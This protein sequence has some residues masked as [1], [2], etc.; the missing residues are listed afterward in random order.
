MTRNM[1]DMNNILTKLFTVIM[2]MMFS[3][4]AQADVKVLFGEDGKELQPGKDGTITLP[5][6]EVMGGTIVIT[7]ED[8]KDGTTKVYLSVAPDKD[9]TMAK[10]GPEVYAVIS[11]DAA[12]TRAPEVSNRLD[13]KSDDYKDDSQK[14]TYYVTIDSNLAL[15][16]KKVEFI[17]DSKGGGQTRSFPVVTTDTNNP[18][19]YLIQSF[20]NTGFYM[21]PSVASSNTYVYTHNIL[22]DDMKWFFLDAGDGYYYICH[23]DDADIKYMYFSKTYGATSASGRVWIQLKDLDN[24]DTDH[25]KFSFAK[26]NTNS[27]DAYN[28]IPKGSTGSYCLNKRGGNSYINTGANTYDDGVQVST[29]GKGSNDFNDAG[30]NWNF[31]AFDDSYEWSLPSQC[32]TVSD[33]NNSNNRHFYKVKSQDATKGYIKPGETYVEISTINDDDLIW[34]FEEAASDDLMTYY[35]IRHANTGQYLRFCLNTTGDNATNLASR[36]GN[37]TGD[38]E[39]RFQFIVVRGT[40]QNEQVNDNSIVFNIIPK[41]LKT[42]SVKNINSLCCENTTLSIKQLRSNLE[43]KNTN[44]TTHWTFESVDY[45][46]VC[47]N[48]TITFSN[49]TGKATIAT[50]TTRSTIY[51][52]TDGTDPSSSNGMEYGDPFDVTEQ[53]TIKAIVTRTGF[54]DSEVVTKT[55]YQVATPTI[56]DNGSNAISI[57]T[58]TTE[59]DVHIYYTLDES[60]PTASSTE[61]TEPLTENV[62]GV[63]IKTIAVK[64]GWINSAVAS[65]SVTLQCAKPIFTRSGASL[66]ITCNFPSTGV[67]IYYTKDGGEPSSSSNLYEGSITVE[68]NDVI[69]AVAIASGYYD[70]PVV[71]KT[72]H[73]DLSPTDGKYL[74]NSQT[75][76]ET[77]LDMANEE[78]GASYHYV[79]KTNV[80]AGSEISQ[81]FTGVLEAEAD[82]NGNFYKISGLNHAL[83]NT[84]DGGTVKNVMFDNVNISSGTNVGAIA[85]EASGYTRIYNCGVLGGSV[86]GS[87]YVGG[88]VGWLKDDSRVINCFSYANITSGNDVA[89]IVGHNEI[90]STTEVSDGKYAN[91]KTVVV[92]CMF[93]GN[94]TGGSNRYPVYGG[95]KIVNNTATGINNYDFYRAE[96]SVGTLTDYNCSWPAKEEYLTKYEFYRNLLN[97]N[98]ELCGWWVSATSAPSTMT[99]TA[100]QAVPKDASL[101]AKWVLDQSVAPYPILKKFGKYASSIN[102]DAD[103]SWRTT[104][105][106]WEGKKLG[107]LNVTVESGAQ[108][109][110]SDRSL[111]LT[112]TDMDTLRAD[113]CYRKV[114]LPYYN[115][116][117]G[118]PNG[119]DWAAKYGGN[120]G[121]Y[122]VIGWKVSTTE[123]NAGE[124]ST[125]WETGYNFADRNCTAKDANRVFAQGGYYYVPNGVENITITAQWASAIY[126]DNTDRYYDRVSV[127]SFTTISG[128][129][130]GSANVSPFEP[131]GT[132]PT[133]LGN[134]KTVQIGSISSK[135]PSNGTVYGNAIVLVGNH[136][137]FTG[138][139][140][141][142]NSSKGGTIMSADFDFDDEP[143][144]CLEWQL[145]TRT[146]RQNI[147][148]IR[149]DFLP[150]AELGLAMKEDGSTQYY[151]LGCY[152]P[153]GHFEV[154]ETALI[155][156]GQF[157]FSSVR[158]VS[159]I[160][161]N[162]GIFDQYTKG[163]SG[164]KNADQDQITY[165]IL[166]GNVRMPSFT[167]GSH[168]N[169]DYTYSTRHC[170]VSVLGG[171]I[172]YLYLTGNYNES[173]TPSQDNPHCY[174]DG[175][176]FK[177][178]AAAGK[179]GINGDVFFKINHSKIW[180]F[181][182][183]STM[184][185][186]GDN[187][188][189]IVKG[190]IDVTIDNSIV[191]KY[192]GGPK[193]G[194]M[195]Y[196]E[197]N[198]E[199]SKT[200][201]TRATGTTFG[202]YYG[203]GNGGTSY[204]Q[205]ANYDKEQNVPFSL[206]I[207]GYT[208]GNYRN[209]T[210]GYMADYN[211]EIVNTSAG[212][213]QGRAV[214]RTYFFAAQF[215]ATNTGSITNNLTNCTI[216]T[217]FYGGGNLGGVKGN[218]TSTLDGTTHVYGS[219]FGAG[220]SATIPEVIIY[221]KNKIAPTI[222]VNTGI[223]TPQS[224]GTGTTYTWT[225]E[226]NLGGQTLNTGN[227]KTVTVNGVNY[228][229]TT[230]SLDNLGAVS[231][232]VTLTIKGNTIVEGKVFNEDGTVDNTKTGGVYGGGDASAVFNDTTPANAY[233][234]V[235]LQG[236]AQ[237]YGD[238]FGGGN[239]G[240]VSGSATVN[241]E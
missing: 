147:C 165:I 177:Q 10:E 127:S 67:S 155:H 8:Q 164:G 21:K 47:A 13:L 68:L 55:I 106:E 87:G 149:F 156:F 133:A 58:S 27:W 83:F 193:F 116:V 221:D 144:Y 146:N 205:Y 210:T 175:G 37:E 179:E 215:S 69:K 4:G 86:G 148:P 104:A 125:N 2:L 168:V 109:S 111:K 178:V 3:M 23:K 196:D 204:V 119:A 26:N 57:T 113:Y 121:D 88:L 185:Q 115:T 203:G 49:A 199:N 20:I 17:H 61:Y 71:T 12:S 137:Y 59:D 31:I 84:V 65:N 44:N 46:T 50:T 187:N 162:G 222:D 183:G 98:R 25:F 212:T 52:T 16:V 48:P 96:A 5:Q 169:V 206:D 182:G 79:L 53:T 89:G 85:G 29:N 122:V 24:N 241:I 218:V 181:Y 138:G 90:A 134:G 200:I 51:Y 54:T 238:V 73:N 226:S 81:T 233:T 180:E 15:W 237:V 18:V 123:G 189:K 9:Y 107:E 118:D 112:I 19:Y 76:F 132:R 77:F 35:Y 207:S 174:I 161:L 172:D 214:Y 6:K 32:F 22:T 186:A 38:D 33:P 227:N 36:T 201:T 211:M 213:N 135:M 82:A 194:D 103:A 39:A 217:N 159:P 154:T 30:S 139:A 14:R 145:G 173:V 166:G 191:D 223:I 117:F 40:K 7:Q 114:Q 239:K 234:I 129:Q 150:I 235:N 45:S 99:T 167:P 97:S 209:E 231:G 230:K 197:N 152:H 93:Y 184:D 195:I 240:L 1:S 131:A 126:L 236:N 219:A 229:Y 153:L 74:I 228:L 198:P 163:T 62:S 41:L 141:I 75:D 34:Y 100:V 140:D 151:S 60:T 94:I 208:P 128:T 160:I 202:V 170:A 11:P 28:I 72:I 56:Q 105:N 232:V 124:L 80:Y 42:A 188:F 95:A 64:D 63:T 70:S 108:S 143:D 216:L 66:T 142:G 91:L 43:G 224:G 92:N 158:G 190:N 225:H 192:C 136:Q 78:S 220:F 157:E 130:V 120:Y 171:N 176:R 102:I 101:I 110:L